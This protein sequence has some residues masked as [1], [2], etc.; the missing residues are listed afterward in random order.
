MTLRVNK[1]K[2]AAAKNRRNRTTFRQRGRV[3]SVY[4]REFDDARQPKVTAAKK[5][6]SGT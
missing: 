3:A 5:L 6:I 1:L 4:C 2:L